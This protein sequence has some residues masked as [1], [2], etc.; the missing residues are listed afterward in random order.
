MRVFLDV[1]DLKSGSG[2][3]EVDKSSCILVF[4]TTSYFEKYN[5][6]KELYRA[7]C[8]RRPILAM[9]EPDE[10]QEGGLDRAAVEALLTQ[11]TLDK[12]GISSK[13]EEWRKDG[14]L[15]PSALDHAPSASELCDALFSREPVEWNRLPHFQDVT[16]RL[17][18]QNGVLHSAA[19]KL[20]LQ[21]EAATGKV[22]LPPPRAGSEVGHH[23][24]CSEFNAGAAACAKELQDAG[25]FEQAKGHTQQSDELRY[26]TAVGSMAE[27]DHML[28]LLDERTWMSGED[29]AKLV[30]HI[31]K[32]MELGVHLV[33]VHEFPSVVGPPRHQ[34]E[35]ARMFD[36][37]WTPK[38][39]M[40][41][42]GFNVYACPRDTRTAT[43]PSCAH[44][45][46]FA[47]HPLWADLQGDCACAQGERVAA[48][49][50]RRARGQGGRQRRG[51]QAAGGVH[52]AKHLR[53]GRRAQPVEAR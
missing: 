7:V 42:L 43:A 36:D 21:G 4:C 9:L 26:T 37:D 17:I 28:V 52:G 32:A 22:L 45:R 1:D 24:F 46:A 27:C 2:T 35:F 40:K 31:H 41:G 13:W 12:M 50:A 34:C 19:G 47:P 49:R 25:V 33:C 14:E 39:L 8:Q 15:L 18:A 20:Y 51:A 10:T 53:A 29:T 5:S 44:S 11:A 38:H 3:A 48:A 23:L 6:L 16:I 30:E